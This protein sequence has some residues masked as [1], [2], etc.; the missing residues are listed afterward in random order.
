MVWLDS[1]SRRTRRVPDLD[2]GLGV[3]DFASVLDVGFT[4]LVVLVLGLRSR[5]FKSGSSS[6]LE[7][8]KS[9]R[10][11]IVEMLGI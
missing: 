1:P 6:S 2:V 10:R 3:K 9:A 4:P 7:G 11:A 8:Q 5:V